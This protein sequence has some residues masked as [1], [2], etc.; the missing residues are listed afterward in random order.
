LANPDG[1]EEEDAIGDL[2]NPIQRY[3]GSREQCWSAYSFCRYAFRFLDIVNPIID[4]SEL[5]A[6]HEEVETDQ[7][8][9]EQDVLARIRVEEEDRMDEDVLFYEVVK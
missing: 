2:L 4:E 9:W 8:E 1:T 5:K 3:A 7:K 6:L